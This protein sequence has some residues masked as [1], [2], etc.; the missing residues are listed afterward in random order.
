G[1][2]NL[3]Y[4]VFGTIENFR[5]PKTEWRRIQNVCV[6]IIDEIGHQMGAGF[7]YRSIIKE[8]PKL[9]SKYELVHILRDCSS[10][11]DLGFF[12]FTLI[13]YGIPPIRS[14]YRGLKTE[15]W[16]YGDKTFGFED[17]VRNG[18]YQFSKP[19]IQS[20][21]WD[22]TQDF[23]EDLKATQPDDYTPIFNGPQFDVPYKVVQFKDLTKSHLTDIYVYY[24]IEM[25]NE[26]PSELKYNYVHKTGVF[27]FD[28]YFN[29]IAENV[30]TF[31]NLNIRNNIVI[32]NS[33]N[34][35][36]NS[37]EM[38][39]PPD[40]GNF[41][42]EIIRDSDKGVATYRGRYKLRN[43]DTGYL[44]LSDIVLASNVGIV[45]GVNGRINRKG[46]SILPNPTGI[47]SKYQ[48]LYIYYEVYNLG[49]N[50]KG[51]TNFKQ[52]V[53]LQKEDDEGVI[54]KIFS[55]TLKLIGIDSEEKKVSLTS[56][57]K[58]KDKD[59]QIYL[60]LDMSGYEPGNYILTI[61]IK[62]NISEKE[63]EQNTK[64]VWR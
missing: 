57:Y 11:I 6:R 37:L 13:K 63:I 21:Y 8:Y 16:V 5:Y 25:I 39:S 50:S 4:E 1:I 28:K 33:G 20:Q 59:S 45:P 48:D 18:N 53:I 34:F 19:G 10:I 2:Y 14:R 56:N 61:K 44:S 31:Q 47:F 41:C 29:K 52:S 26:S 17:I 54:S 35:I 49:E 3:D 38:K 7:I 62:D 15:I 24:G 12:N 23:I 46:Y 64:L 51:L 27:F 32:P 36:I 55:P 42:F 43:F 58:T 30:I 9:R 60:Q 22:D 40:S